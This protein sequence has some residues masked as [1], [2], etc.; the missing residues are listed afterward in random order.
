MN[1]PSFYF[2]VSFII[3][4]EERRIGTMSS[5]RP[6]IVPSAAG[7]SLDSQY[8]SDFRQCKVTHIFCSE[9]EQHPEK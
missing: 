5:L 3:Q 7:S 1:L 6:H 8:P 4:V 9:E 2:A